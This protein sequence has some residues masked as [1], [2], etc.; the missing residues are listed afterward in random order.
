MKSTKLGLLVA[1]LIMG[2][3]AAHA[4][5]LG[6]NWSGVGVPDPTSTLSPYDQLATL[7][8]SSLVPS[9]S[10]G[11][12]SFTGT[13]NVTC[14]K[15][16]LYNLHPDPKCGSDGNL[17]LSGTLSSTGVLTLGNPSGFNGVGSYLGGNTFVID[18]TY[19]DSTPASPDIEDWTFTRTSVPEP[20]TL[21]LL[22]LGLA[23]VGFTR[24][25]KAS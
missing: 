23:G 17:P 11:D 22:G 21:A 15:N 19:G 13:V 12:F 5:S 2:P 16:A 10:L 3:L 9:D 20:T 18:I 1:G 4:Q 24:R 25:R 8:I 6:G 7:E 14:V